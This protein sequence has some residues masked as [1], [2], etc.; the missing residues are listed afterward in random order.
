MQGNMLFNS[1][2]Q[3]LFS[4]YLQMIAE[5]YQ[6]QI[7]AAAACMFSNQV[8][9]WHNN[10][11]HAFQNSGRHTQTSVL[12]DDAYLVVSGHLHP[13]RNTVPHS[14]NQLELQSC[15]LCT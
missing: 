13:Q 8:L 1:V 14:L 2:A 5:N 6:Q 10:V 9:K 4:F 7:V 12:Q 11:L 3:I 15:H